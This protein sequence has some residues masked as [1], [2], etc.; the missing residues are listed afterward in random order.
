[1]FYD[2]N[3]KE[4][5]SDQNTFQLSMSIQPTISVFNYIFILINK[6]KQYYTDITII[7]P[8]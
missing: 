8:Y 4:N 5:L 2:K 3:R 1:M 7:M 6:I